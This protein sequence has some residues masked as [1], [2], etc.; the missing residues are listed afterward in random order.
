M[1]RSYTS[2]CIA[3]SLNSIPFVFHLFPLVSLLLF[4]FWM[5]SLMSD[6][7]HVIV[8]LVDWEPVAGQVAQFHSGTRLQ[9]LD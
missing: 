4:S 7:A 5:R 2:S 9:K 3:I 1:G 6:A 8:A